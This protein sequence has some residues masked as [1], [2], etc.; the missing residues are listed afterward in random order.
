MRKK[1]RASTEKRGGRLHFL[2]V[3]SLTIIISLSDEAHGAM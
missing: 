1:P 2:I 3:Y